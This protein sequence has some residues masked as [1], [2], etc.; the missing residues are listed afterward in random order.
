MTAIARRRR[1]NTIVASV[2]AIVLVVAASAM[3]AVGAVTLSNSKEGEAVGIDVRPRETFPATPNALL[4]VAGDDGELAS[5]VV[6]TLLPEG[7]GGS[8]VTIAVNADSTAGFGLQ[9]RPI[10][11]FFDPDDVESIVGP[12]EEMLSVSIQRAAIVDAAGLETLLAPIE[13]IEVVVPQDVFDTDGDEQVLVIGEGPHT[14]GRAEIVDVL[15]A[16]D[17]EGDAYTH[18]EI[19]VELWSAL[20][21]TAPIVTPPEPVPVDSLGTP[22]APSSVEELFVRLWEGDVGVRDLGLVQVISTDNPTDADVVLIDRRDS[23]MV[24]AQISPGLVS[25]PTTGLN[26]RVVA[27]F[28][29]EQLAQTD[30]L[31][32]STSDLLRQFI[33]QMFVVQNNVVSVDAAPTGAPDVTLIEVYDVRWLADTEAAAAAL[34][35]EAE[36]R[37]ADT[38]LEGVDLEVTLGISYLIREMVRAEP[39]DGGSVTS[40]STA[41]ATDGTTDVDTTQPSA[42]TVDTDD[43]GTVVGDG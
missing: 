14:L 35:G 10:D 15:T 29:D 22:I 40:N 42:T 6:L 7:Q 33:G 9:R 31:F 19:D 13:Q 32:E 17:E 26:L 25:T 2:L 5:L 12:V 43:A 23:T 4:A 27:P 30:G 21:Q 1:R 18:H 34:F 28:T 36:V 8:I 37:L 38:T 41:P 24:F 20:A 16:V 39:G 11:E 3:V